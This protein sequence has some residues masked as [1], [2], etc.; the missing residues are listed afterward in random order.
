MPPPR[1]PRAC[2]NRRSCDPPED[3]LHYLAPLPLSESDA[4]P[5]LLTSSRL[6]L[7]TFAF[8]AVGIGAQAQPAAFQLGPAEPLPRQLNTFNTDL[9]T[10]IAFRGVG[11]DSPQFEDA[12]R[13]LQP[14]GLRFPGGTQ[15]N[16]YLWKTD[17]FSDPVNDK[18][19]WAGEHLRL[20]RKIGRPYDLPGFA[21]VARRNQLPAT[22]VLNVYEETAESVIALFEKLDSLGLTVRAV[23]MANEPYWDGRSLN[24]VKSY[25]RYARPLA[26]AIRKNRPGI[27][28]GACF[29]PLGNPANYEQNWNAPL[30]RETWYDAIVFH[31]YYGGQGFALEAGKRLP[32]KAMLHPEALIDKP[33]AA[34][35]KLLPG[36]PIWYTEWNIGVEGLDQW[37]NRGAELQFLAATICSLID[38]R[39]SIDIAC[40]HALYDSRFGTFYLDDKTGKVETNASFELFRLLGITL[41]DATNLRPVTFDT[42][43]LRGFATERGDEMRLF[44]LNRSEAIRE[45]TLPK[46]EWAR[47]TIDCRPERQL[48]RSTPLAEYTPST[49]VRVTLPA[50]SVSL[51]GRRQTLQPKP[52]SH[53]DNLFPRR[54]DLLLWHAPYASEQPRFDA[55]GIYTVDLGKFRNQ[56]LVV[57]K[58][59]LASS[60]LEPG[61]EYQIDIEAK[62]EGEGG[63]IAKLPQPQAESIFTLLTRDYTPQRYTFQ[64]HPAAGDVTFVF[65]KEIIQKSAVYSFRN[66]RITKSE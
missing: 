7:S 58:M 34:F 14:Q 20:F 19:G 45:L 27:R 17:T 59:N 5:L 51:I 50:N 26:E 39:K 31:D 35:T 13:T 64:Y 46:G 8:L 18:T 28:I 53:D 55:D 43:D 36:K 57:V 33:V 65:P 23:E 37:K 15:A 32:V 6:L 49:G 62:I 66:F 30:A 44:V 54:P 2:G 38:H 63:L 40:F 25:I 52:K 10:T 22:W 16:N 47:L 29:A 41:T 3:R 21:R 48:P 1:G 4:M 11:Y 24:D 60:K 12:L 42:D 9:L 61:R 56:E